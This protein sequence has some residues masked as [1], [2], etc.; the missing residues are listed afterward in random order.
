MRIEILK[1]LAGLTL[2]AA[3]FPRISQQPPDLEALPRLRLVEELRIGN[4]ADPK[5]GFS[6]IG[7]V[8]VDR[9][10]NVYAFEVQAAEIRVFTPAGR[11]LRTIGRRGDGPGEFQESA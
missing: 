8:A 4:A 11:A 3:L 6:S 7:S 2:A 1:Q 5:L 10:G 9:E